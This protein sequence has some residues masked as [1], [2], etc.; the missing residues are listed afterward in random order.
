M[1]GTDP[2]GAGVAVGR[3]RSVKTAVDSTVCVVLD[4]SRTNRGLEL[5][6]PFTRCV[7]RGD[8]LELILTDDGDAAP[9]ARV[10][11]AFGV[12]F[13]VV[14]DSGVIMV[15]DAV[16]LGDDREIGTVVGFDVSHEPNHFNV[17]IGAAH[18]RTGR[19]IGLDLQATV[20]FGERTTWPD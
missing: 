19:E 6:A 4:T 16:T 13:S 5:I 17:V 9:N 14:Q 20:R 18:G 2:Y 10:D 15:G 3:P 8:V 7:R 12:A 11:R 1:A